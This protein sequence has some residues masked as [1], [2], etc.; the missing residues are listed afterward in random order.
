[1]DP[2]AWPIWKRILWEVLLIFI[3]LAL[4]VGAIRVINYVSKLPG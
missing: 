1:M 4:A 2:K 3:G